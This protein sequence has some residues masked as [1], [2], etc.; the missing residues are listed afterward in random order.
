MIRE[1][2]RDEAFLKIPSE[3]A[4]AA[5]IAVADDL[6]DTLRANSERCVGMAAN[7]IGVRTRVIVFENGGKISEMFNPEIIRRDGFYE[8]E[9][10][11]LSLDGV[12]RTKRYKS[13]KVRWQTR[14]F[15]PRIQTFAG[16]AAQI[17][18]HEINH[19]NGVLI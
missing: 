15:K 6:I 1:I 19:L 14:D 10:G 13:I 2:M 12:R 9:E 8:A 16:F 11:C 7:M 17:I 4:T 5:D 18:Q 3:P